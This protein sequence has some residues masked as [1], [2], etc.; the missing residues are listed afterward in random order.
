MSFQILL[1]VCLG[2]QALDFFNL[3]MRKSLKNF[4]SQRNTTV[5]KEVF[6]GNPRRDKEDASDRTWQGD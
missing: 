3:D 6:H 4:E 5:I 2:T 1:W